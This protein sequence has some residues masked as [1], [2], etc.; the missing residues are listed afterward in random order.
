MEE[1][2]PEED[3]P[4]EDKPEENDPKEDKPEENEP[5]EDKQLPKRLWLNIVMLI[6]AAPILNTVTY[7]ILTK[8][9]Y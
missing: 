7:K 5:K 6:L 3:E 2:E 1:A 8:A 4:E 9:I